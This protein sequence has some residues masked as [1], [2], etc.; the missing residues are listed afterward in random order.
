MESIE[1]QTKELKAIFDK[2]AINFDVYCAFLSKI[3]NEL[4]IY[5][6]TDCD[7]ESLPVDIKPLLAMSNYLEGKEYSQ[8]ESGINIVVFDTENNNLIDSVCFDLTIGNVWRNGKIIA[9]IPYVNKNKLK[10]ELN[11]VRSIHKKANNLLSDKFFGLIGE[12][13]KSDFH[14]SIPA[15]TGLLR[16]RQMIVL[17]LL[18]S[19]DKVCRRLGIQY[20]LYAGTLLGAWRNGGFIPSDDDVDVIMMIDDFKKLL[21]YCDSNQIFD[22][23]QIKIKLM[24]KDQSIAGA[25]FK[26]TTLFYFGFDI[27][28]YA[29]ADKVTAEDCR[30]LQR[31]KHVHRDEVVLAH[32]KNFCQDKRIFLTSLNEL[33]KRFKVKFNPK[34]TKDYIMGS[35]LFG[36]DNFAVPTNIVLPLQE[37]IFEGMN[38]MA[39]RD[40]DA[41]LNLEFGD[42]WKLPSDML[43]HNSRQTIEEYT[44]A[45]ERIEVLDSEFYSKHLKDLWEDYCAS[46]K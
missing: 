7:T 8:N 30:T 10:N 31:I 18:Y 35:F 40:A 19:F 38:F 11:E 2:T 39:P 14:K 29:H 37:I 41:F 6:Y 21:V 5:V 25:R 43:G 12:D 36:V 33:Y 28:V 44:H 16:I 15:A 23:P 42:Y 34:N 3:K 17:Y 26:L 20:F 46:K 45:V 1:Q 27:F 4:S 13:S 32:G 9:T 22:L 24:R